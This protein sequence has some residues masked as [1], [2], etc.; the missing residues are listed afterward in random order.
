MHQ[1]LLND[2]QDGK[3]EPLQKN[4]PIY[5]N[6][7]WQGNGA[8]AEQVDEAVKIARSAFKAWAH[9]DIDTRIKIV[10]K[11]A[12]ALKAHEEDLARII[13]Q[14]TA[15]PLWETRTEVAASIAKVDISIKAY[16]ERTPHR[17]SQNGGD[18][19]HLRHRP[20]GVMAVFGPYNFPLHLPNGHIV[21]ALIAGNVIVFKPSEQTPATGELMAKIWQEAGLPKGV[22][23]V[24][25]GAREVGQALA[26][27]RIDGLLFTGS[28][29]TGK[30]LHKALAGDSETI[31]ALEMGGNNALIVHDFDDDKLDAAVLIAV[32]S[33]F[34]SAGQRCTCARRI[35]VQKG[36]Q[37]DKFIEKF[38]KATQA[39]KIGKYDDEN[40]PFMGGLVS[41]QA[42]DN[43]FKAYQKLVELGARPLVE[44]KRLDGSLLSPAILSKDTHD[45]PDEEHFGPMTVVYRYDN[46]DDAIE[47]ANDTDFGLSCALIAKER[48]LYD[49]LL[50]EARAGVVNFNK[51]TN[52]A[53]SAMPFGGVG[54]SG[55]HRPS[56]YYAADYC[57]YPVAGM[58]GALVLPDNLPCGV[59]I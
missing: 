14:E 43:L 16:H 42:A 33:A 20:H 46:F 3:G 39:L 8:S 32:Q 13:A 57:A 24:V 51:P 53:S 59:S 35:L 40:Q 12:Q 5:G 18:S 36:A 52:G 27:A 1:I 58:A 56:A 45:L 55:N 28:C 26:N 31:L 47:M 15:K 34:L 2:W 9:T 22:L 19:T 21:P 23:C 6:T 49:R 41:V 30:H 10:Q 44:M 29:N 38:V 7:I 37:G 17:D 48:A 4:D 25:Q 54:A 50:M 11:Y